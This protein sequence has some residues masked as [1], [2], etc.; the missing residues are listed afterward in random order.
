MGLQKAQAEVKIAEYYMTH[1]DPA[2]AVQYADAAAQT[3]AGW[4]SLCAEKAHELAGDWDVAERYVAEEANH[5]ANDATNWYFWCRRT[6]HGDEAAARALADRWVEQYQNNPN[7]GFVFAIADVYYLEGK[8]KE[9]R[10][11]YRRSF[12]A[13]PDPAT[14][15]FVAMTSEQ[16]K[17]TAARDEILKLA[18]EK[19]KGAVNRTGRKRVEMIALVKYITEAF[20]GN[21][22]LD[23]KK[24]EQ[25]LYE[26]PDTERTS[27]RYFAAWYARQ[28]GE[29]DKAKKLLT[30]TIKEDKEQV[31]TTTLTWMDLRAM[32]VDVPALITGTPTTA[33][34]TSVSK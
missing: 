4:A 9:A 31:F 33:P 5:Y 21:R 8:I 32:G 6:G 16:L 29:N 12:D 28:R 7:E 14:A 1:G 22:S 26:T 3:G 18:N 24:V 23:D 2:Q 30:A 10:D 15:L 20:A 17:D 19:A 27:I 25:L 13:R 11:A 34:S